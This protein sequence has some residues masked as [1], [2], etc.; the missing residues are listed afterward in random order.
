MTRV[1]ANAASDLCRV[2]EAVLRPHSV[3]EHHADLVVHKGRMI[4][5]R[6]GVN[7]TTVSLPDGCYCLVQIDQPSRKPRKRKR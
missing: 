4:K 5:N 2:V 1:A 7:G 3:A 6:F